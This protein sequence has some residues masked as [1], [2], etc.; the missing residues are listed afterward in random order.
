[1]PWPPLCASRLGLGHCRVHPR[2][3]CGLTAA[4]NE[5]KSILR[6]IAKSFSEA[7]LLNYYK[8]NGAPKGIQTPVGAVRVQEGGGAPVFRSD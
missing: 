5:D 8:N 6:Q 2:R 1:M 4:E 7:K 3:L